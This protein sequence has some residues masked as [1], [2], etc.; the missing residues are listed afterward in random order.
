MIGIF[1]PKVCYQLTEVG[2]QALDP[3]EALPVA[4][5]EVSVESLEAGGFSVPGV[6]EDFGLE[7]LEG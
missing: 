1:W 7:I 3:R 2:D 6:P 4:K 5:K